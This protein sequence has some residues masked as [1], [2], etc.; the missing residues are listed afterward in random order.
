MPEVVT[1]LV[2][3]LDE[4]RD[5][6]PRPHAMLERSAVTTGVALPSLRLGEGPL[7]I[8][9]RAPHLFPTSRELRDDVLRPFVGERELAEPLVDL[10]EACSLPL[11]AHE[12]EVAVGV[13]GDAGERFLDRPCA[14]QPFANGLFSFEVFLTSLREVSLQFGE[15]LARLHP[16]APRL[17][18]F[19]GKRP[20]ALKNPHRSGPDLNLSR[21]SRERVPDLGEPFG[22]GVSVVPLEDRGEDVHLGAGGAASWLARCWIFP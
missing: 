7:G 9:E 5:G 3:A 22:R 20:A 1:V 12:R 19:D 17:A 6:R 8:F 15:G 16:L 4:R 10:R 13:V 14:F 2:L 11:G 21:G 18:D